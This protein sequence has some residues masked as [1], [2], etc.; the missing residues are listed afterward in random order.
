MKREIDIEK[1]DHFMDDDNYMKLVDNIIDELKNC[2]IED[3]IPGKSERWKNYNEK[4]E[5]HRKELCD[6]IYPYLEE[7]IYGCPIKTI[8]IKFLRHLKTDKKIQDGAFL[9][10]SDNHPPTTVN[11]IVY[12]TDVGER[13]GGMEWGEH[14]GNVLKRPYTEPRGGHVLEDE[15]NHFINDE[16]FKVHKMTGKKG[17]VFIFDN[18]IFHRASLPLDKDRDAFLLQVEPSSERIV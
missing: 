4:V 6:I 1:L 11:I 3:F 15:A 18:C 7:N 2:E 8:D 12:L 13:D 5:N 10:H 16:N 9:W 17:T 14:N